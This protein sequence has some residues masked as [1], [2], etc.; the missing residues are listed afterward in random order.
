MKLPVRSAWIV[1]GFLT[2]AVVLVLPF[3]HAL[4][5]EREARRLLEEAQQFEIGKP[6]DAKVREFRSR[7]SG[8]IYSENCEAGTC[9]T[10]FLFPNTWLHAV[11]RAPRTDFLV[12]FATANGIATSLTLTFGSGNDMWTRTMATTR[13]LSHSDWK[14]GTEPPL[15]IGMRVAD[16]RP[17]RVIVTVLP[18]ASPDERARSFG[19]DLHCL[20][21]VRGCRNAQEMLP[22]ID[23]GQPSAL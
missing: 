22:T 23:W 17:H 8:F 20:A 7:Y 13:I 16:G 6:A 18:K 1:I 15:D 11:W 4:L 3:L 14:T 21:Q 10:T 9:F 2:L 5:V 19:F 12:S